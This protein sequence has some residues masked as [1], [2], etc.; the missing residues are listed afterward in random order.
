MQ[1][2]SVI[3]EDTD[4]PISLG[5][6]RGIDTSTQLQRIYETNENYYK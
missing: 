6:P 4:V 1:I 5:I 2:I 3:I